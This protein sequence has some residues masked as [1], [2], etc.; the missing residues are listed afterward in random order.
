MIRATTVR[1]WTKARASSKTRLSVAPEGYR[2]AGVLGRL[3]LWSPTNFE[4]SLVGGTRAWHP[5]SQPGHRYARRRSVAVAPGAFVVRGQSRGRP[6]DSPRLMIYLS[7]RTTTVREWTFCKTT[8]SPRRLRQ[9]V[10]SG[11]VVMMRVSLLL[12]VIS[13]ARLLKKE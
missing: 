12:I 3:L 6:W 4:D 11:C 1:E 5:T 7:I 2:G 10:P 9:T 13:C 8:V